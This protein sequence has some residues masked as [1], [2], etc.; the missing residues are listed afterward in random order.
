MAISNPYL[1]PGR[2]RVE[3]SEYTP[4]HSLLVLRFGFDGEDCKL[5]YALMEAHLEEGKTA[6][7]RAAEQWGPS[8]QYE[9]IRKL[10]QFSPRMREDPSA[11]EK[12]KPES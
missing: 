11:V 12:I 9:E 7:F 4:E 2:V 5:R 10:A 6:I 1:I 8:Y 3:W